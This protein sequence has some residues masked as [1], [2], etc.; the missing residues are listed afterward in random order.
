MKKKAFY[1]ILVL[2]ITFWQL[3][4]SET[5]HLVVYL[6]RPLDVLFYLKEHF[7]DI[8]LKATVTALEAFF[9]LV[10][11]GIIAM[12]LLHYGFKSNYKLKLIERMSLFSQTIP[13]II[14]LT[15]VLIIEKSILKY[16]QVSDLPIFFYTIPPISIALFFTP[17]IN[18][19][20]AVYDLDFELKALVRIWNLPKKDNIKKIYF[21]IALPYLLT[22]IKINASWAIVATLISEGMLVG[23]PGYKSTL[24]YVLMQPF[25]SSKEKGELL[26]VVLVATFLGFALYYITAYLQR[27]L[28]IKLLG[29]ST[30]Q[31]KLY[32]G[33][34]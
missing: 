11:S 18:A 9:A 10:F 31:K 23:I 12:I 6:G 28:E 14:I 4:V 13:V 16:L 33:A 8:L 27:K 5:Q 2:F 3:L 32:R 1:A 21:P 15:V 22:G 24:G 19:S 7:S 17:L 25:S 26:A 29:Y 20:R 30:V 34:Q